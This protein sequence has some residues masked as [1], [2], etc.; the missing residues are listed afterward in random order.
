MVFGLW[1]IGGMGRKPTGRPR[2]RPPGVTRLTELQKR[3][4]IAYAAH[5][6][7]ANAAKEAGYS[8]KSA[9][10]LGWRLLHNPL[11]MELVDKYRLKRME[12]C[13]VSADWLVKRLKEE[14]EPSEVNDQP[15]ARVRSLELLGKMSGVLRDSPAP[16]AH[17]ITDEPMTEAEWEEAVRRGDFDS[18]TPGVEADAGLP[19]GQ[20]TETLQ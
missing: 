15:S 14:A 1:I 17:D 8:E 12:R 7:A 16:V 6:E 13:E 5:P 10:H 3:F 9:K 11:V 2:G 20:T 19:D 4:A 18:K